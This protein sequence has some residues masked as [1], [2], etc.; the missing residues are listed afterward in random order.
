MIRTFLVSAR[1]VPKEAAIGAAL[2]AGQLPRQ[3]RPPLCTPPGRTYDGSEHLNLK[4]VHSK[5]VPIFA[6]QGRC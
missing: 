6:L 2:S 5:N 1:K 3:S 4:P